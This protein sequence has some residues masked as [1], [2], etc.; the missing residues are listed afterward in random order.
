MADSFNIYRDGEAIKTDENKAGIFKLMVQDEALEIFESNI[1]AGRSIICQPYECKDSINVV[2]VM[3]GKLYHTNS[4]AYVMAG[5]YYTFKDLDITHHFS[6]VEDTKLLMIR[7][8]SFLEKQITMTNQMSD[9]IHKIQLKD[10]YTED[11]CNNTGNLA[12]EIATHL[13]LS[14]DIIQNVLYASKIHDI[15]KI[16]IPGEVLNKAGKLTKAEFQLMKKHPQTGYEI[17]MREIANEDIARVVLEHHERIDG[18]GY[19]KG[20]KGDEICM[21]AK[22]ILVAD[23]F[24]AMMSDRPYRKAMKYQE[25]ID[26]LR[27]YSGRW[28]EK[29]IVEALAELTSNRR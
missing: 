7:K 3:G 6:V 13:R 16:D 18:S 14:E 1:K 27:A 15:G 8:K 21:E 24:D 12:V 9:I 23:S 2:F 29:D 17:V 19:P 26:E 20:L 10:K 5:D 4:K 28:Y 25:A 11:H 22:V